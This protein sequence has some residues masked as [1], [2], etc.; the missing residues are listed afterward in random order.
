MRK[1]LS[2]SILSFIFFISVNAQ[3]KNIQTGI[4]IGDKAPEIE[5]ESPKGE[6]IKLSSLEG[7]IVLIDFWASWCGPCRRENVEVV[8]A[9]QNYKDKKFKNGKGFTIYSV[10]LDKNKES[11]INAIKTDKLDWESH[12][13]DLL[14]WNSAPAA[15]YQVRSIPSNVIIDGDGIIL[16]KNL[17]GSQLEEFLATQLKE[18]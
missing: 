8:K 12:V 11:W 9:Y 18:D 10:S 16:A 4:N 15:L 5:Y 14:Y 1:I 3:K 13:S 6:K 7:K 2:L 17:R